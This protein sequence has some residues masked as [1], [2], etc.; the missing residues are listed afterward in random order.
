MIEDGWLFDHEDVSQLVATNFLGPV[1]PNST[2]PASHALSGASIAFADR[3][4]YGITGISDLVQAKLIS[5]TAAGGLANAYALVMQQGQPGD[6]V[7]MVLMVLV[8]GLGP[9]TWLPAEFFQSIFDVILTATA[10]GVHVCAPAGNGNRSLDEPALLGRFDRNFR[11]SGA[12]IVGASDG[13]L[14]TRASYSNWG[15]RID[16]HSWG[17]NV[18]A[19]GYGTLFFPVN[20][21][22]QTYTAAA[23]GTSSASPHIAG[24]MA[25]IQGVAK[26]QLGVVLG[27]QQL[28]Q[29]LHNH[30]SNTPDG[31]G[32]RPDLI[33]IFDALGVHDGL[34]ADRADLSLGETVSLT[35]SGPSGGLATLFGALAT[36]DQAIGF[37]R[38]LHLDPLG[39][40]PLGAYL[41]GTPGP[42]YQLPVPVNAAL[43][44]LD[45]YF[46][47]ARLVGS[48]PLHLTNSCH[49]T[50]L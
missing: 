43:H 25:A 32:R 47:A 9:G 11:D 30:G 34:R 44:G 18:V 50:I 28:I 10:S 19:C 8:P 21:P 6:V 13:G 16:A 40:V 3:N 17:N 26:K 39:A 42:H 4:A 20:D 27:N 5:E 36:S 46:Q 49:V 38:N 7:M 33:A 14:L 29:L 1:P 48:N 23:T 24:V 22:L 37:N 35:L 15:S 2:T 31:I 41:L 12:V 45:L